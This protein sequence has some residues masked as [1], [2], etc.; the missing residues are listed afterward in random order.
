MIIFCFACVSGCGQSVSDN[1]IKVYARDV[2][3][4]T[5]TVDNGKTEAQD[6]VLSVDGE[7]SRKHDTT[8]NPKESVV[9]NDADG[10]ESNAGASVEDGLVTMTIDWD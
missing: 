2:S 5:L 8:V 7:T 6:V 3:N 1:A 10:I 4:V 9:L